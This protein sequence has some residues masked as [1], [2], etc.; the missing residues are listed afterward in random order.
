MTGPSAFESDAAR[1]DAPAVRRSQLAVASLFGALGF[2]YGT[3]TSRL[4]AIKANLATQ[5]VQFRDEFDLGD[6]TFPSF[7]KKEGFEPAFSASD[8][9]YA[10]AAL[11]DGWDGGGRRRLKYFVP[12]TLAIGVPGLGARRGCGANPW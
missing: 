1:V 11:L 7:V 3:W 6:I 9:A 4:P 8:Y 10:V 5:L 12:D 2:S